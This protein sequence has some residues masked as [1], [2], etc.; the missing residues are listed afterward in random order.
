VLKHYKTNRLGEIDALRGM[1]IILMV[2]FHTIVDLKDFYHYP[3]NYHNGFW[4]YLGK[5]SASLFIFLSGLSATLATSHIRKGSR[6]FCCGLALTIITWFYSP[7]WYIRFG[8]LHFLGIS[9]ITYPLVNKQKPGTLLLLA[10][11][12]VLLGIWAADQIVPWPL[13]IPLGLLPDGFQT[14]DYYPL[15]PWYGIFLIGAAVGKHFYQAGTSLF[16]HVVFPQPLT[17]LGRHSL[18]IYLIHQPLLLVLL[19]GLHH[20]IK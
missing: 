15:F 9:L 2:I 8:I 14:L 4:Y 19:Y 10:I 6:I 5:S 13:L 11:F 1:A 18:A 16:P 17:F 7:G 20:V 3:V 12:A